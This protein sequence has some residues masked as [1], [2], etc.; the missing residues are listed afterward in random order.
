MKAKK[1]V[2]DVIVIADPALNIASPILS[3]RLLP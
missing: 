3:C 1:S 2:S